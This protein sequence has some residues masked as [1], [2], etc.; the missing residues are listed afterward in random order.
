MRLAF[1]NVALIRRYPFGDFLI[2]PARTLACA[3]FYFIDFNF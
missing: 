2:A 1:A 3:F